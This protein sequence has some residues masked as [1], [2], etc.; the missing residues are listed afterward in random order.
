MIIAIVGPTASGKTGLSIS[1]AQQLSPAAIISADA[2][3]LYRGM[4]IGTAKATLTERQGI[5]H[6]QLDV[7]EVTDEA[8]VAAYQKAAREQL[9][10]LENN[11]TTPIVTGGSGLYLR[12][13]L[14]RIEFPGTDSK[15]RAQLEAEAEKQGPAVMHRRLA[16][17]DPIAAERIEAPNLRRV[18]RALEVI[19]LTGKPFSANLPDYTYVKPTVQIGLRPDLEHL[20][21]NIMLRTQ[22]MFKDGLIE[23]TAALIPQGL[24]EGKTSSRATG[25]AQALAVL[26]GKMTEAEAIESIAL[27]TRQLA[28]R[29]IKWFRRDPRIHWINTPQPAESILHQALKF[30]EQAAAKD[31]VF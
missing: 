12:A 18:I 7:L 2:M 30:I 9:Q 8:S 22:Q 26:D 28:R 15:L 6:Y 14:D 16:E 29:Q 10:S 19:A 17:Q 20:D 31:S 11:G 23:E 4:D 1:V 5:D 25:Y 13:L 27:A 3:Q 24:R 21:R